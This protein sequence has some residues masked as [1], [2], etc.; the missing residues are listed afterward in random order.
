MSLLSS[1][2]SS[3][4]I[5]TLEKEFIAYEPIIQQFIVNEFQTFLNHGQKW[6]ESKLN[7]SNSTQL[8]KE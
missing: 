7:I 1:W 3:Q 2:L 4:F 8:K 6:I 5:T